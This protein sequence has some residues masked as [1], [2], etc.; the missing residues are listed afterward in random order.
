MGVNRPI[1]IGRKLRVE[2][3]TEEV[4]RKGPCVLVQQQQQQKNITQR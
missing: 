3:T 1:R 2:L 4:L